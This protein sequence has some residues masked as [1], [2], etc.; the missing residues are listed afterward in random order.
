MQSVRQRR[1]TLGIAPFTAPPAPWTKADDRLLGT[2][3]DAELAARLGRS[4]T[5][6]EL[7]RQ[8]RRIAPFR[9]P[10]A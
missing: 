2:M 7:R 4:K 5:A 1:H 10:A 3:P 9:R 6:I 8:Q